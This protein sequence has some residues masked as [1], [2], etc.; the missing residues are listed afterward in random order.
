[1]R[2]EARTSKEDDE[3]DD[4]FQES[5][6]QRREGGMTEEMPETGT[7]VGDG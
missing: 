4:N 2:M 5:G 3:M 1:M 6:K 7:C